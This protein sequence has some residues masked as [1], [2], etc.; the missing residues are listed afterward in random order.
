VASKTK[1]LW[2]RR[3]GRYQ[4]RCKIILNWSFYLFIFHSSI[5]HIYCVWNIH[6]F[7]NHIYTYV[8]I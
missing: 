5:S 4:E 2:T 3:Q 6:I 1:T 8:Y 7:F